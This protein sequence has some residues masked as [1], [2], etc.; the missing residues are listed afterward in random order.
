MKEEK[1]L[2]TEKELRPDLG[3]I[4]AL[5]L[6]VGMVLGAGAFMKPPAVLAAAGDF[7]MALAAWAIGGLF[8]IAG[9]L[10]LCELGV[11][12]PRTGGIFVY[13][14]ELYGAKVAFL[15]GW[16]LSV[17]FGPALIGA[18]TGYFSS[19]FCLLFNI[20]DAYG[21]VV[22][23]AALAFIAIVNSVGVKEAGYL[24][25][26]AT[27]CKLIP[28]IMLTI[29]GLFKGS[30][31]VALFSASGGAVNTVAPFSVAIL[32]TLFAYDGWAQVASVAGEIKNPSKILPKAIIGGVTFLIIV[33][34]SI[35]VAMFKIFP[36]SEMVALG[37]DASS[38]A[39]QKMFGL[40]GGNLI[41]VGIMISI[42]GGLNGYIMT[43]SR[44]IYVMGKRRQIFGAA[45]L[46]KI[47]SDSNSPVN[48]ILMLAA[49]SYIYYRLLD[50]DKL[51]DIAMFSIWLFYLLAFI[52]IFI[53]R[54]KYPDAQRDYKVPLYPV[55]PM[56]AIG[57]AVYVIYGMLSSQFLN[58]I[59]SIALTLAGL[60]VYYYLRNTEQGGWRP[61]LKTKYAVGLASLLLIGLLTL[62]VRVFDN[63][64]EVH[65]AVVPAL[66]PFT[67]ESEG[68]KLTGF[69][70][71]LMN[72]IAEKSGVK[73]RYEAVA[74]DYVFEAVNSGTVDA[75]VCSLSVTP[76]RQKNVS[77]TK[78]YIE[79]GGLAVMTRRG[80]SAEF[81]G[82]VIGVQSGSTSEAFARNL[83][84]VKL[85]VFQSN[86]DMVKAFN[87]GWVGAVV[88]DR[89]I[90]N[91]MIAEKLIEVPV[92]LQSLNTEEYAIAFSGKNKAMGEKFNKVLAEMKQNGELDALYKKWFGAELNG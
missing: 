81:S 56:I 62:S 26:L 20:P 40:L 61:A 57:G 83:G 10:T 34:I 64:Q 5:S 90:L 84:N 76:E 51:S 43:L 36:V 82:K 3:L 4:S 39:A 92:T 88:F 79:K 16:M 69:D 8:S 48:A 73:V 58:G 41:A 46:S 13:L 32:A 87:E 89:L 42:L 50:A 30:G 85:Q 44:N 55:V 18:L 38:I 19:V 59:I 7:N 31:Q 53:A 65:V 63:R 23:A 68:A 45:L 52:G 77:F 49:S 78:P 70:I 72:I 29:F 35:N 74:L 67:Y 80:E 47:D 22:G 28:I 11:L 9:G 60:P 27:F 17:I 1:K 91:H 6:V 15:Y 75:A 33:Y 86:R 54:R 66:E 71:E 37:H 25:T 12:F 2:E 24:Q 14:E 21:G